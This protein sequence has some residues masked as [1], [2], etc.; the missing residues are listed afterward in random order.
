[1]KRLIRLWTRVAAWPWWA[2]WPAKWAAFCAVTLLVLFPD[3]RHLI[4]QIGIVRDP[5]RLIEPEA[6]ALAAMRAGFD[7]R[8]SPDLAPAEQLRATEAFVLDRI[9]YAYDWEIWNVLDYWPT[10]EQIL[11]KGKEDC[12]GRAVVAASL[13]AGRGFEPRLAC[14]LVHVWVET[15]HGPCM[16]PR[17]KSVLDAGDGRF[18]FT[19]PDIGQWIDMLSMG[20]GV[21]PFGR[22]LALVLTAALLLQDPR[23]GWPRA[24]AWIGLAVL[25]IVCLRLSASPDGPHWLSAPACGFMFLATAGSL[26]YPRL[27]KRTPALASNRR[28][29]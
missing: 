9:P 7:R 10:V 19:M 28:P 2:R 3:P 1:M 13:L 23:G 8:V 16:G 25:G 29:R 26:A 12:D 20:A 22:Q 4:R 27:R 15:T 6:P 14:D 11:D 18:T 24:S 5:S 21:F 17:A